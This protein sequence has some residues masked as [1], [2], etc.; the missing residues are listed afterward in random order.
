MYYFK[1]AKDK[2]SAPT[3]KFYSRFQNV[4]FKLRKLGVL[5][6]RKNKKPQN[7]R[8]RADKTTEKITFSDHESECI[9]FLKIHKKPW[10]VIESKWKETHKI[11]M[12]EIKSK[13]IKL[14][15]VTT[16]YPL[17]TNTELGPLL[18]IYNIQTLLVLT[19]FF[20]HNR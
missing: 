11:R 15:T 1:P 17:I 4:N 2:Y 6:L 20:A 13:D 14:E 3:G 5:K 18:V 16:K 7:T 10:D 19:I 8:K 9:E 12:R